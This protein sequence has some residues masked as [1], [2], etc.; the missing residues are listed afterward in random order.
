MKR[1]KNLVLSEKE[2]GWMVEAYGTEAPEW[3]VWEAC[4]MDGEQC[5]SC[6]TWKAVVRPGR[7]ACDNKVCVGKHDVSIGFEAYYRNGEV[8]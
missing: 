8:T 3:A 6:G 4:D 7:T 2:R 1:S 5:E